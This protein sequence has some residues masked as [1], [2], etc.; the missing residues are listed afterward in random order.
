VLDTACHTISQT[1]RQH[2]EDDITLLLARIH[3][4]S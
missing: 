3:H 4:G 2:G 1:L